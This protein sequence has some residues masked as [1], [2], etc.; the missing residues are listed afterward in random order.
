V[1]VQ[2]ALGLVR[3]GDCAEHDDGSVLPQNV[4][5]SVNT[6]T[7]CGAGWTL[8]TK[9]TNVARAILRIA[10]TY[11]F[12]VAYL[13]KAWNLLSSGYDEERTA[14]GAAGAGGICDGG[15][16]KVARSCLF[17]GLLVLGGMANANVIS[18]SLWR[19][20]DAVARSATLA[21]VPSTAAD[22][23]FDVDSPLNFSTPGPISTFLASGGAFNI[24]ENT[25]GALDATLSNGAT[26]A[27]ITFVGLVTVT[28]GQSFQVAHDDGLTLVIGDVD[29]GFNVGPT[30]PV[31]ST[32]VYSGP[33]G[34]FPF[35]LVYGECC[36]GSAVLRV[37]LPFTNIPSVPEPGTLALLGL[38]LAGLGLSR[39]R[40]AA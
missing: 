38:G 27:L 8:S 34:T 18:G 2:R 36:G 16:M 29:L 33:S 22:V 23:T 25:P 20:P 37:D 4:E 10:S 39:R 31:T 17:F 30:A 6:T 3:D 1:R 40:L 11:L 28:N 26:S 21:N 15:S 14:K 35:Q 12:H 13:H 24:V 9:I 32:A 5:R 19:V 7:A